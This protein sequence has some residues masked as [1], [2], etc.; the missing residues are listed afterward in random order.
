MLLKLYNLSYKCPKNTA[1]DK[2]CP[3][4]PVD[5]LSLKEKIDW[6]DSLS[7]KKRKTILQHHSAC[8][9]LM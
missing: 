4:N 3:F 1:R 2:D 7:D 8:T 5:H 6:I 9:I